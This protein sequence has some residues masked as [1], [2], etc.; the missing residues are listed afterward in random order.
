MFPGYKGI[1][2]E[3]SNRKISG[4]SWIFEISYQTHTQIKRKIK[5]NFEL[6]ENIKIC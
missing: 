6:N 3:I 4:K 2:L 1:K 5:M